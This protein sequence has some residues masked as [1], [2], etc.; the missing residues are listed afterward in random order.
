MPQGMDGRT[1]ILWDLTVSLIIISSVF[2]LARLYVRFFM[3]RNPGPDDALAVIAWI[4]LLGQTSCELAETYN[5]SG[6]NIWEVPPNEVHTYFALLATQQLLYFLGTGFVRLSIDAVMLRLTKDRNFLVLIYSVGVGI[7]VLTLISFCI[8]LFE[9]DP[10]GDLWDKASGHANCMSIEHEERLVFVHAGFGVLFDCILLLMP[11][12]LLYKGLKFDIRA[13]RVGLTFA[14]GIFTIVTGIIR[15]VAIMR[16][17]IDVNTTY[18][19]TY[20]GVWTHCEG[21]CGL[22]V[23][24]FPALLPLFRKAGH[25]LG[26]ATRAVSSKLSM[27]KESNEAAGTAP[28]ATSLNASALSPVSFTTFLP[29]WPSGS[30]SS[31]AHPYHY[32]TEAYASNITTAAGAAGAAPSGLHT[33]LQP[34]SRKTSSVALPPDLHTP[35]DIPARWTTTVSGPREPSLPG[36]MG[37][38]GGDDDDDTDSGAPAPEDDVPE[39]GIRMTRVVRQYSE[40]VS[41]RYDPALEDVR[42]CL[43]A[44]ETQQ[45]SSVRPGFSRQRSGFG[46]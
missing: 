35:A 39:A 25:A 4:F 28:G 36:S 24:C 34:P 23:A 37:G 14:V 38:G 29:D 32:S 21:H 30:S 7:A 26:L 44:W 31:D 43:R 20:I 3:I 11:M 16:Y 5:G 42:D 1:L 17:Q 18:T 41:A 9:C 27:A 33:P 15:L 12:W 46:S 8:V 2:M 19:A 40:V 22:W 6:K 10:I 13:V 45:P